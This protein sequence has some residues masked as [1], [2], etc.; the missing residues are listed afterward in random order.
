MPDD[1]S[2]TPEQQQEKD[3]A[4]GWEE[5]ATAE[6][7]GDKPAADDKPAATDDPTKTADP[8]TAA[9][10]KSKDHGPLESV[11]KALKDTKAELT[12]IQQEKADLKTQ[13]E[14]ATKT[15]TAE[16]V[17]KRLQDLRSKVDFSEFPELEPFFDGLVEENVKLAE[18]VE[19]STAKEVQAAAEETARKEALET[20]NRDIKPK[21]VEVHSDFDE[22]VKSDDYWNWVEKQKDILP[23]LYNAA[24]F[25]SNPADINFAIS[26]FKKANADILTA[27]AEDAKKRQTTFN[28]ARTLRGGGTPGLEG[29][30]KTSDPEDYQGGWDE[31]G[32]LL[33][34][35]GLG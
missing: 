31:A 12:R 10:D 15:G 26:E 14:A 22:I 25:S 34:R 23:V 17:K 27:K 16:E 4:A 3:Y 30:K 35:E 13:L 2:L 7:E 32:D 8:D 9:P 20:F 5:A 29:R 11:E 28:N 21:I 19:K 24:A 1:E 6:A 33:K 18:T